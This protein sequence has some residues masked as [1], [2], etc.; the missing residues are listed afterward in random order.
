[1]NVSRETTDRLQAYADLIKQW[2]P[3]INLVS[4]VTLADLH[5]RHIEDSLQLADLITEPTGLLADLGSGG[6]LPGMVLAIAF[7]GAPLQIRLVESDQRKAV[8]LRTVIRQLELT[9]TEVMAQRIESIKPLNASY[10]SARALAPLPRLM[11]YLDLHMAANGQALLMKGENW[12]NEVSEARLAWRFQI[13]AVPSRTHP[14]AA[15]LAISGL[16]HE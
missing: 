9:N 7:H 16:S 13:K 15:I 6:G 14:G 8:F 3:R 4:P 12:Q 1:M 11:P 5:H 2:N 10:I